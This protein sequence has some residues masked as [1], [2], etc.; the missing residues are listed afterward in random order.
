MPLTELSVVQIFHFDT[1]FTSSTLYYYYNTKTRCKIFSL[2]YISSCV[3][4]YKAHFIVLLSISIVKLV[5]SANVNANIS[6]LFIPSI[7]K[8]LSIIK[9]KVQKMTI[10]NVTKM[11]YDNYYDVM[12]CIMFI[13]HVQLCHVIMVY[14]IPIF[15]VAKIYGYS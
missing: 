13:R 6:C 2:I 3:N 5:L 14:C 11:Q 8:I 4:P 12:C 9:Y 15:R 7:N 10:P 1:T